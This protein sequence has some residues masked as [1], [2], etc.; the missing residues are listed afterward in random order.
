[1]GANSTVRDE[2]ACGLVGEDAGG[3]LAE[4][5]AARSLY[6]AAAVVDRIAK[7][8]YSDARVDQLIYLPVGILE[9]LDDD[10][11]DARISNALEVLID[12]GEHGML[13]RVMPVLSEIKG[14]ASP[15]GA[16]GINYKVP[17]TIG[18]RYGKLVSE[19]LA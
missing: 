4:W 6:D 15:D 19:T 17:R 12:M 11:S 14:K 1:V 16:W 5:L 10:H 2:L 18:D 9:T 7:V 8:D 3:V 13:D